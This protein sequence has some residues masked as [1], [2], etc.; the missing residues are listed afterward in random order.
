[1]RQEQLKP[2]YEQFFFKSDAG[3]HFLK[4]V[5]DQIE[6]Y[7]KQAEQVPEFSRDLVQTAKGCREVLNHI[8]SVTTTI[9]KGKS[10]D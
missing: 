7:H 3:R 4:S 9:K 1:M 2:A 8:T 10:I 6:T 5:T